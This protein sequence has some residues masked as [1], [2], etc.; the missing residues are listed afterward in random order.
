MPASK[1]PS[2]AAR[3]DAALA[4]RSIRALRAHASAAIVPAIGRAEFAALRDDIERRGLQEAV[5][6]TAAGVVLDGQLRLRATTELGWEEVPVRV[7]AP[8][9]EVEF[10]VLAALRRRHLTASQQAALVVELSGYR[11]ETERASARKLANLKGQT[12]GAALPPRG[13]TRDRAADQAGVS[14]RTIQD[15]ATVQAADPVLFE[16]VKEGRIAVDRA[17][18]QVRQQQRDAELPP[19]PP[20]P[21]GP[22]ELIYAD[23]PWRLG[24]PDGSRSIENHYPTMTIEQIAA[25]TVPAAEDA[26]LF[27]WAVNGLLPET[28]EIIRAWGFDYRTNFAWLKDKLGL[29]QWNRGQHELLLFASRGAVSP[30]TEDRRLPSVISAP[31]GRHSAKPETVYDHIEHMYPRLSKLE[32]FARGAGRT[33]WTSWGNEAN[34]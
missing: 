28:L 13:K 12:E 6:V 34:Q 18:R 24:R 19:P 16:Q 29:G 5:L 1:N 2:G 26:V 11:E 30:P 3:P 14:P 4:Y 15:A 27:L 23:P 22:F 20:P 25:L 17:A 8:A 10:M 31:R 7:V 33:G 9:D 32:L 21:E